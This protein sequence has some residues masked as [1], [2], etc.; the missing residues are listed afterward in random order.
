MRPRGGEA[1][2]FIDLDQRPR[3]F[4]QEAT[5]RALARAAPAQQG[6]RHA[7]GRCVQEACLQP[8]VR[9][10]LVTKLGQPWKTLTDEHHPV[11]RWSFRQASLR[12]TPHRP[13]AKTYGG[14]TAA[15]YGRAEVRSV[16][17]RPDSRGDDPSRGR[18]PTNLSGLFG[19]LW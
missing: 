16:D 12:V 9:A 8:C 2:R 11:F 17:R 18:D 5:V 1:L 6:R 19:P 13:S 10:V 7:Q 3:R 15:S 14:V 4:V